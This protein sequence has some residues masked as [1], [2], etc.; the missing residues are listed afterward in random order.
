[1]RGTT[2]G[3]P[4]VRG[5]SAHE[6]HGW[7]PNALSHFRG[8]DSAAVGHIEFEVFDVLSALSLGLPRQGWE[9]WAFLLPEGDVPPQECSVPS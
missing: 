3:A 9:G 7:L 1:M 4:H 6:W 5:S 8:V 2:T